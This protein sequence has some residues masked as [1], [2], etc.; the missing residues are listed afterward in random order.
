MVLRTLI[1]VQDYGI[2]RALEGQARGRRKAAPEHPT[3]PY[4][5]T[6]MA[7]GGCRR[8]MLLRML[9]MPRLPRFAGI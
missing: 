5:F 7:A 2:A 6:A 9:R 3:P 4:I 1:G 8:Q